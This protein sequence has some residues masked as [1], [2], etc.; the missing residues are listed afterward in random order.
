MGTVPFSGAPIQQG[1]DRHRSACGSPVHPGLDQVDYLTNESVFSL[2][3]LPNP[4]GIIGAGPIGCELATDFA[5]FGVQ[6]ILVEATH[7]ILPREEADA[8][9]L[10]KASLL[11]DGVRL[12]CC[13]QDV[14]VRRRGDQVL[15]H[16]ESHG[17]THE[18][19]VA[20]LLVAVGTRRTSRA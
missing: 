12:L 13:G 11:Q 15:L 2:T 4:I 16:V 8:A 10:V 9:E 5:R 7:G 17:A 3:E 18:E 6:V 19:P 20:K 14:E 1:G